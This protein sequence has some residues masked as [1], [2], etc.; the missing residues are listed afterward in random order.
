MDAV[1][2][3]FASYPL[4]KKMQIIGDRLELGI[5]S[6]AEHQRTFDIIHS[7]RFTEVLLV[8][9]YFTRVSMNSDVKSFAKVGMAGHWLKIHKP[10][11]KTILIKGSRGIMLEKVLKRL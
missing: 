8:G 10:E 9:K 4:E 7:L 6:H 3:A 1:L 2:R 5:T 11:N